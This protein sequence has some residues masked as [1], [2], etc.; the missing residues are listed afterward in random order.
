MNK[1]KTYRFDFF[2]ENDE[3]DSTEFCA[4][5]EQEAIMLFKDWCI[6]DEQMERVP[7]FTVEQVY[8]KYDAAE[9]GTQYEFE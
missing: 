7:E 3:P 4:K 5:S 2:T 8:N 6:S 1:Y 9:Y